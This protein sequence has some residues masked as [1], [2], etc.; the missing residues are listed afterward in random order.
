MIKQFNKVTVSQ[1]RVAIERAL[2]SLKE[3]HGISVSLG[4]ISYD[5]KSFTT[6]LTAAT[7]SDDGEAKTT[8]EINWEAGN[9]FKFGLTKDD[10]GK[11]VSI[12]GEVFTIVGCKARRGKRGV[13]GRGVNGKLYNLESAKVARSIADQSV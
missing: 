4:T 8:Y 9:H 2:A 13:I 12:Y 10:L 3:T 7:L 1:S 5:G 11:R 6:K